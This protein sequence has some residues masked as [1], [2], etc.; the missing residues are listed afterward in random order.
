MRP[1]CASPRSSQ[2]RG[3]PDDAH[4]TLNAI[5]LDSPR[6]VPALFLE[7]RLLQS[8]HRLSDALAVARRAVA[9]APDQLDAAFLEGDILA[10]QGDGAGSDRVFEHATAADPES[11]R[12]YLALAA[13]PSGR[14][15]RT[16][17]DRIDRTGAS[18]CTCGPRDTR[19]AHRRACTQWTTRRGDRSQRSSDL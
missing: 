1:A 17:R 12:P 19:D 11:P 16:G 14:R 9:A 2:A 15:A 3:R 13:P 18:G 4:R 6:Y 7:A 8:E 5:L 10:A